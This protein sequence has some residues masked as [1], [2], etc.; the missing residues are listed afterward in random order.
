MELYIGVAIMIVVIL[1]VGKIFDWFHDKTGLVV[2]LILGTIVTG[3]LLAATI[4]GIKEVG[5]PDPVPLCKT[6]NTC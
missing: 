2:F 4:S 6:M 1:V 3:F 5:K